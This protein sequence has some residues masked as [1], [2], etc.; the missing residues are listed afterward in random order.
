MEQGNSQTAARK[1]ISEHSFGSVLDDIDKKSGLSVSSSQSLSE[2]SDNWSL[3]SSLGSVFSFRRRRKPKTAGQVNV[4]KRGLEKRSSGEQFL[5]PKSQKKELRMSSESRSTVGESRKNEDKRTAKKKTTEKDSTTR[6]HADSFDSCGVEQSTRKEL[7]TPKKNINHQ[8]TIEYQEKERKWII[9]NQKKAGMSKDDKMVLT[10]HVYDSKQQVYIANCHDVSIQIHGSKIKALLIDNCSN[11]NVIFGTV[12]STCEVV[13]CQRVA[14]QTTGVCPTFA[15]DQTDGI[16]VWLS[17]ES[18]KI[19]NF[20]TSKC[21]EVN[22]SIPTGNEDECDR[23]EVPLP[24]Q[25]VHKFYDGEVIS[26]VPELF[27]KLNTATYSDGAH[28]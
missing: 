16:T 5:T 14:V 7:Q 8:A 22:V 26:H 28:S 18:M 10:I 20:V 15:V 21:T 2:D 19:S 12:I 4:E 3:G 17:K 24:E 23:K 11:L 1:L 9:A 6:R 27:G 13:N 25:F